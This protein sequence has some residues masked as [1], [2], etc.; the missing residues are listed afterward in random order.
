MDNYQMLP[1]SLKVNFFKSHSLNKWR[2]KN[3][4][5]ISFQHK[6]RHFVTVGEVIM[7]HHENIQEIAFWVQLQVKSFYEIIQR[8]P[9]GCPEFIPKS[10][11]TRKKYSHLIMGFI[12]TLILF[13]T[14]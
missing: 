6:N 2:R 1:Y 11:Y 10:V 7:C 9:Q 13:N 5:A 12:S 8:L 14:R 4:N 3:Q